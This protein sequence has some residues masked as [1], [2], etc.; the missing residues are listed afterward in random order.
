[1]YAFVQSYGEAVLHETHL[2][3]KSWTCTD[4]KIHDMWIEPTGAAAYD[5]SWTQEGTDSLGTS[6][7]I[8]YRCGWHSFAPIDIFA[9]KINLRGKYEITYKVEGETR[10]CEYNGYKTSRSIKD[11]Y[12]HKP[13]KGD[14]WF[15]IVDDECDFTELTAENINAEEEENRVRLL[16]GVSFRAAECKGKLISMAGAKLKGDG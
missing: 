2:P 6:M 7:K 13:E 11:V 8:Y 5:I 10:E 15:F 4:V 3:F 16:H 1:M 12:E 14:S 9:M